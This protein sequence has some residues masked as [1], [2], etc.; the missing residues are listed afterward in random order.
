M[1]IAIIA[2]PRC[3]N[4][5]IRRVISEL[6]GYPHLAAHSINDFPNELPDNCILNIHA[7]C[8]DQT[9]EYFHRSSCKLVILGRH[10]LDVFVSVL[11]FARREPSVHKWL[12][13]RCFIPLDARDLYPD[14][15]AFVEW[16]CS[17]GA[18]NLLSVTLSWWKEEGNSTR[19]KYED[20]VDAPGKRFAELFRTLGAPLAGS[21]Q[22]AL[23]NYS[24]AY[25]APFNNHGWL[26]QKDNYAKF[27]TP[28]NLVKVQAAHVEY[29]S[30]LDYDIKSDPNLDHEAARTAYLQMLP[31]DLALTN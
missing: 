28:A 11:Q 19:L 25:F 8:D 1:R 24:V 21:I 17:E 29:F 10:P 30:I 22:S 4:N 16:M 31:K 18:R 20:V 6:S 13:G 7:P 5:W 23:D 14:S 12:D 15:P 26:G 3:G 9:R 2:S 27:I